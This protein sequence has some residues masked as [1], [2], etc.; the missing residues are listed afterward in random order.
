[1]FWKNDYLNFQIS[2]SIATIWLT[3]S[4]NFSIA[5]QSFWFL[6]SHLA[7]AGKRLTFLCSTFFFH[8]WFRP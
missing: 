5:T 8:Y 3:I 7:V 1:L 4:G 2:Q 6:A